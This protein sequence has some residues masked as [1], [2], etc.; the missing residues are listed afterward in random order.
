MAKVSYTSLILMALW[1][2]TSVSGCATTGDLVTVK[3]EVLQSF[4]DQTE[5]LESHKVDTRIQF[6]ALK[7][8]ITKLS[9]DLKADYNIKMDGVRSAVAKLSQE[10]NGLREKV[11]DLDT[12][13]SSL[14]QER[15]KVHAALLSATRR[16]LFLFKTEETELKD[17]LRFLQD[18]IKEYGAEEAGKK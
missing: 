18:A 6:E 10:L 8:D 11:T 4:V 14:I 17:R 15:E 1:L 9:Q 3:Q 13:S 7:S 12:K 16:I 5:S 2:A